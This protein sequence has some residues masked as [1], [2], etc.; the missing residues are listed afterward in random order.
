MTLPLAIRKS[1]ESIKTRIKT[2]STHWNYSDPN[3]AA[4][5]NEKTTTAEQHFAVNLQ[6]ICIGGMSSDQ[7][8]LRHTC[9]SRSYVVTLLIG[10]FCTQPTA[11]LRHTTSRDSYTDPYMVDILF[12]KTFLIDPYLDF[13][14][15]L[16]L[17]IVHSGFESDFLGPNAAGTRER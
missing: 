1:A 2:V 17:L 8:L 11:T 16:P 10:C 7:W 12:S 4:K 15:Q 9:T 14:I 5:E 6:K 13:A 3:Y